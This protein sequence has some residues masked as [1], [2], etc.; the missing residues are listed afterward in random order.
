MSFQVNPKNDILCL[1]VTH[2]QTSKVG[3]TKHRS[4]AN[5]LIPA[6]P[7]CSAVFTATVKRLV[8][9]GLGQV[10][11]PLSFL[12]SFRPSLSQGRLWL[13]LLQ[14]ADQ[15]RREKR[16][17]G[18]QLGRKKRLRADT[19]LLSKGT[20]GTHERREDKGSSGGEKVQ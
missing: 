18:V 16:P 1:L 6:G 3:H 11:P 2:S 15:G 17:S 9:S 14:Y 20:D 13:K 19:K 7:P 4:S 10:L 5:F 12:P 8:K